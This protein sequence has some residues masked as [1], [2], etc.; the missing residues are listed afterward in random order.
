VFPAKTQQPK[1]RQIEQPPSDEVR[2]FA[3]LIFARPHAHG[4][5]AS[6]RDY[7]GRVSPNAQ[8]ER[9]T[10]NAEFPA[11]ANSSRTIEFYRLN[12][13][14]MAVNIELNG[15]TADFAILNRA[16][17]SGRR[18]D[19]RGEDSAAVGANYAGLYFKVHAIN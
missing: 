13:T 11:Q 1:E 19:D 8:T 3:I 4:V 5:Q 2:I 15:A 9:E 7:T 17:R 12:F 18:V 14:V 10:W 6:L 16:K